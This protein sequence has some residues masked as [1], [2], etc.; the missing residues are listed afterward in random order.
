M[1]SGPRAAVI[2]PASSWLKAQAIA[3]AIAAEAELSG[4]RSLLA[5]PDEP[6][7]VVLCDPNL[8]VPPAG[9]PG[10]HVPVAARAETRQGHEH[11]VRRPRR[12]SPCPAYATTSQDYRD[13][14]KCPIPPELPGDRELLAS[15]T[16]CGK[17]GS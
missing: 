16:R 10:Q 11:P 14:R 15:P 6:D 8:G 4:V 12:D 7:D 13:P 2:A 1:P 3:I 5:S 9:T 17:L